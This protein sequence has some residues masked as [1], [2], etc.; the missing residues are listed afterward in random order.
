[1][2]MF[3]SF[4]RSIPDGILS[5]CSIYL[6]LR[7][8]LLSLLCSLLFQPILLSVSSGTLSAAIAKNRPRIGLA[9]GGGGALGFAHIGVLKVL[10][11]MQIPVDFIAGTSMGAIIAGLYASGMSPEEMQHALSSINWWEIL[12]DE[13]PRRELNFR[14][15][16]DDERYIG[17]QMGIKPSGIKLPA[18]SSAGQKLTNLLQTLT[19]STTHIEDFN[20]LNIPYRAV[21]TDITN[22]E[23]VIVSRGNLATAMRASMAVPGFFSPV[24]I[25]DR[26]L[27][28]G[29]L[30]NN[31]PVDVV[32]DMGADV[33]IAVDLSHGDYLPGDKDPESL[34]EILGRTYAVMRQPV[35]VQQAAMAD[36]VIAPTLADYSA[37]SFHLA[38]GIIPLGRKSAEI[39]HKL[40]E[41]YQVDG[42][43]YQLF[44]KKQRGGPR[45]DEDMIAAI[46]ITGNDLVNARIIHNQIR[47]R[48][49]E[50]LDLTTIE[51]D[52]KRIY[53][54]GDFEQVLFRLNQMEEG[55]Y[56]IEYL[57]KEKAWGPLFLNFGLRL[58]GDDERNTAW[59]LLLNL[60]RTHLNRLG[61]EWFTDIKAGDTMGLFSEWYQP[62]RTDRLF[63]VAPS[64]EIEDQTLDF[65]EDEQRVAEYDVNLYAF[66]LDIGSQFRTYGEARLGL[67][68][69]Y[70]DAQADVGTS[71]LPT[72]KEDLRA[73]TGSLI[74][75][76]LDRSLFPREGFFLDLEGRFYGKFLG[77]Q[78][79]YEKG[80]LFAETFN[81]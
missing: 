28:D 12:K 77:G 16:R 33:V 62:L 57:V 22:G 50:R 63:F 52:I 73:V 34:L 81:T 32:R 29:G 13:T 74:L 2:N 72:V 66:N 67:L 70:L 7:L 26:L 41:A 6:N 11:E 56:E 80:W 58:E 40:L 51:S 37:G 24:R 69:G 39:L 45:A 76:R 18:A 5:R 27:V 54:L 47:S 36:L 15:K 4:L 19:M 60:T 10:E 38:D 30:V 59:Q 44:L 25:D 49:D 79:R 78:Q 75:D 55:R 8:F 43:E 53:G 17:F 68:I 61:G 48:P 42:D 3:A 21:A 9:L 20:G 71:D 35:N 31:L 64:L 65:F 23:A 14:R 1:M 46:R